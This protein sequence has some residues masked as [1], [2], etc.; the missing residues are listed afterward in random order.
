MNGGGEKGSVLLTISLKN[1]LTLVSTIKITK[2][3][4]Q[5]IR[6]NTERPSTVEFGSN[7]LVDEIIAGN[8]KKGDIPEL[9]DG[10]ANERI[11]D[12]LVD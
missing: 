3:T 2:D 8:Y 1:C 4:S 9:W 11:V 12:I 10:K 5:R 7:T 6:E